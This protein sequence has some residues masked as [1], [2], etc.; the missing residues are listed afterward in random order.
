M[1]CLPGSNASTERVFSHITKI[2]TKEKTQL[3]VSTLK[4][5]IITKLNFDYTCLEFYE[6]LKNNNLLLKKIVSKDKY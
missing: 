5:L 3:N 2:W 1:L 6:L 4:A